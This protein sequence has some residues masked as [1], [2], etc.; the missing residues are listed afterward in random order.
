MELAQVDQPGELGELDVPVEMR[1][2]VVEHDAHLRARQ[3]VTGRTEPQRRRTVPA[4]HQH[5]QLDSQRVDVEP[6]LGAGP[7]ELR[8][9]REQQGRDLGVLVAKA[10]S[11]LELRRVQAVV[12]HRARERLRREIRHQEV[13]AALPARPVHA[14][15]GD[16]DEVAGRRGARSSCGR[17]R[18]GCRRAGSGAGPARPDGTAGG[19]APPTRPPDAARRARGST[20]VA[21]RSR[22]RG[23]EMSPTG[24]RAAIRARSGPSPL[25]TWDPVSC[26]GRQVIGKETRTIVEPGQGDSRT[27]R[28]V[29]GRRAVNECPGTHGALLSHRRGRAAPRRRGH[30]LRLLP[31]RPGA[32]RRL[33]RGRRR[34]RPATRSAWCRTRRSSTRRPRS[35][36]CSCSSPSASSSASRSSPRCKT[37]DL[38]RRRSAGGAGDRSGRWC[39]CSPSASTGAA[40]SSPASWWRSA[41][42]RSC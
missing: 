21:P 4:S 24:E 22:G 28:L 12:A 35:A 19:P 26:C 39:C 8:V 23:E 25:T 3:P 31:P 9:H 1:V 6:I 14:S 20:P 15:R 42:R 33:P 11:D 7:G 10:V 41:R 40:G 5:C 36:S 18:D 38:R 34:H 27:R 37:A 16:D 2:H 29:R 13:G 32:D 17:R 30:R